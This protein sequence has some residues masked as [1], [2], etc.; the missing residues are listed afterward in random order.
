MKP[1][2]LI[3]SVVDFSSGAIYIKRQ[4]G[5]NINAE[6]EI[7]TTQKVETR[8]SNSIRCVPVPA[9]VIDELIVKR[10]WYEK[11]KQFIPDF[12]DIYQ[13]VIL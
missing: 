3:Y 7:L 13:P 11:Q 12:H 1:L 10:A 6:T 2:G 8:T 4:L 5:S 9:W